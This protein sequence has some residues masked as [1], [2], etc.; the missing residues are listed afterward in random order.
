MDFRDDLQK[1]IEVL[2]NGGLILYP[3]DTIWAIGCDA[4]NAEAVKK[5]Y[6]LKEQTQG[7]GLMVLVDNEVRINSY[8]QEVPE[9]AYDLIELSDKPISVIF[10]QGKN[11]ANNVMGEDGS[12]GVRVTKENFSRSLCQRFR[13]PVVATSAN[14]KG[15]PIPKS[16][17]EISDEI[18]G[19]VDYVVSF[20]Q[21][22]PGNPELSGIIKLGADGQVQ[23]VRE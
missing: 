17:E 13:K 3:T 7:Q 20:R 10:S 4:T 23:V 5:V 9:V 1:A 15:Q 16:F 19:G 14:I 22:E 18:T 2:Q 6:D 12:I 11:L 21:E 8:V